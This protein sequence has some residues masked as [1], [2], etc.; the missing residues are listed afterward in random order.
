VLASGACVIDAGELRDCI[1]FG[2]SPD[3]TIKPLTQARFDEINA[4]HAG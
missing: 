1:I 4:F 3:L 2:R